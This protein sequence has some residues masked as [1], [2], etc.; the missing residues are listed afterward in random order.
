MIGSYDSLVK[1]ANG[2]FPVKTIPQP[3]QPAA[4]DFGNASPYL[5]AMQRRIGASQTPDQRVASGSTANAVLQQPTSTYQS[6]LGQVTRPTGGLSSKGKYGGFYSAGDLQSAIEGSAKRFA[7]QVPGFLRSQAAGRY[8]QIDPM[9]NEAF[10]GGQK[11]AAREAGGGVR[12][13]EE[14]TQQRTPLLRQYANSLG[15]WYAQQAAPAEEYL[16]TAQQIESEPISN[17]A[18]TIATRAYGMNPD[19]ARGKFAGLDK[20]FFEEQRNAQYMQQY[21]MPYEKYS[22][23]ES[24]NTSAARAAA[25]KQIAQIEASTGLNINQIRSQSGMNDS[26]M[27]NALNMKDV[28]YEDPN[29]DIQQVDAEDII[30][31]ALQMYQDG[32]Q[33][34]LNEFVTQVGNVEGQ[35]DLANLIRAIIGLQARKITRNQGYTSDYFL[36]QP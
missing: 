6:L 28:Q 26:A 14:A 15:E 9:Y 3:Q 29:G 18:A 12:A 25:Q 1:A 2:K 32:D 35:A 24:Q 31:N 19:L 33:E 5:E 16:T 34:G 30:G 21:G 20:T 36:N 27:Y 4:D 17:L 11:T 13:F 10:F 7:T 23:L 22:W 8:S